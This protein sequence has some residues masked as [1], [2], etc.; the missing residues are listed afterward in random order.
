MPN[1][2]FDKS[3]H[4]WQLRFENA[5]VT[6][7]AFLGSHKRI[8]AAN[9]LGQVLI[10]DLPDEP[11]KEAVEQA[12]K[13][14]Y[15]GP[16]H[17]PTT[18]LQGHDNAV[19]RVRLM[20]D[21]KTLVTASY[22]R[23]VRFW[24]TSAKPTGEDQIVLDANRRRE[25][26]RRAKNKDEIL[27]A[28][29]IKIATLPATHVVSDGHTDWIN[30]LG[31]SRDGK[32]MISGDDA[33]NVVVRDTVTR[34]IVT[35]WKGHPGVWVSSASLD[36]D[37]KRAFV[38]EYSHSRGSFDRPPAQARVFD[39]A[40]GKETVDL[41]KIQFPNVKAR[42]NSYGYSRTWGK[43][44]KRG[45]VCSAFSPDGKLLAV[46]QGGETD[47]GQAH[48]IDPKTGK[49]VRTVSDHRYGMCDLM[50]TGDGSHLLTSGRDTTVR[51][52]KVADGKQ[53]AQIGKPRGGQFKDWF[54]AVALSP[55][56]QWL[57]AA[58]MAGFVHVWR[59]G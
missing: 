38:G 15:D 47:K 11:S 6:G 20:P 33:G 2:S 59:L 10:W 5:W 34:K 31:L 57:A 46:G 28:P 17:A 16:D 12:K 44:V 39:V 30:G 50:F 55:D 3:T 22:D 43:F 7:V 45:F 49:V 1:Q 35:Q 37:G 8:A 24:D 27:N 56:E 9:R 40:S 19:S 52:V 26:A 29:G 18:W 54:H 36:S 21:N 23:T 4:V 14:R 48:L 25:K 13:D 53:V 32:R 42:D 41:L 51:V 58:D